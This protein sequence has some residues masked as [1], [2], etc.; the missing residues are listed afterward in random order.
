M[1]IYLYLERNTFI[2]RL[3]P[4]TKIFLLLLFFIL[5]LFF[6]SPLPIIII[7]LFL[8]SV[9][10]FSRSLGN[11]KK[12]WKLMFILF[13]F[14]IILWT[15]FYPG[16]DFFDRLNYAFAMAL[17][18]N[19]LIFAGLIFLSVTRIEEF[20]YGLNKLGLPFQVS[21]ALTLAFRLVPNFILSAQ[22][23]VQAQ[24]SRGLNLETGSLVQR[25]KKFIPLLIPILVTSLRN[26]EL[27]AIALECKGFGI[28]KKRTSYLDYQ[29]GRNDFFA[30]LIVV[31]VVTVFT[32]F[33]LFGK[34]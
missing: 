29:F 5:L 32:F 30:I 33:H 3:H 9:S 8:L 11:L 14:T 12:I 10:I 7:T 28:K 18:L 25:I 21:F 27:L 24:K 23:T 15:I 31:V 4:V 1:S 19:A 13:V 17:R 2:H 20:T 22:T 6:S 16:K 26:A 34:I